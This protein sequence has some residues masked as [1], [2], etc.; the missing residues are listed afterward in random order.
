MITCYDPE[1]SLKNEMDL[2][3]D[4]IHM[5]PPAY[6]W[7]TVRSRVV[8]RIFIP[9]SMTDGIV[10]YKGYKIT[11]EFKTLGGAEDIISKAVAQVKEG[12]QTIL[13][14]CYTKWYDT[15]KDFERPMCLQLHDMYYNA[16]KLFHAHRVEEDGFNLDVPEIEFKDNDEESTNYIP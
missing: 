11:A 5:R 12:I 9:K 4:L 13:D 14:Q 3:G 15:P 6:G 16:L 1:H 10:I 7:L 2:Y 8:A